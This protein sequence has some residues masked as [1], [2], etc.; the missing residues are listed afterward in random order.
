MNVID[1]I[2]AEQTRNEIP[3]FRTGDTLR[4][5]ARIVEG[6]HFLR[7]NAYGGR[8]NYH[9]PRDPARD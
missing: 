5:H 2:E 8:I 1:R 6:L 4:V 7:A 9:L 3:E